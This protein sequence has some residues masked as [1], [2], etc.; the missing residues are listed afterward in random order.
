[1][2]EVLR[3]TR[4]RDAEAA[5]WLEIIDLF[6]G[7]SAGRGSVLDLTRAA[8][9]ATGLT[10]GVRDEWNGIQAQVAGEEEVTHPE[11]GS[12]ISRS[13]VARRLRGRTAAALGPALAAS[14][15]V[16]AGRV[17]VA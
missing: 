1:M 10:A 2:R 13:A 7:A 14:I 6:D 4:D 17:G 3:V 8:A 12:A 9:Q 15:E 11:V 5:R 16:G